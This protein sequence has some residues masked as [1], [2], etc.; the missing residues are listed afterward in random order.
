MKSFKYIGVPIFTMLMRMV[1]DMS[2][3][4]RKRITIHNSMILV[5]RC[6]AQSEGDR[7]L[8]TTF[9]NFLHQPSADGQAKLARACKLKVE[10]KSIAYTHTHTGTGLSNKQEPTWKNTEK[11]KH[12]NLTCNQSILS[13]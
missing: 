12:F 1:L 8:E 3:I 13:Q 9:L 6:C 2:D 11:G 5:Y 4:N 7:N 10:S